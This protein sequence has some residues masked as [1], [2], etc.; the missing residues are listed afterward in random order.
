MSFENAATVPPAPVPL[1]SSDK[2]LVILC[3]VS[4]LIG[5]PLI[6]PFVVWLV[7]KSENDLV[8]AHAREA[9]NFHLSLFLYT[10]CCVPLCLVWIGFPLLVI[11][12]IS[13]VILAIVAAIKAADGSFY[14]YPLTI[15]FIS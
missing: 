8:T 7:K 5:V 2:A 1:A 12:A 3:H 14:R 13:S 10:L 6:L 15:R 9:L 4:S 11:I